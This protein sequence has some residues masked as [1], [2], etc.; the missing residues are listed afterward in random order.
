M[1]Y[2]LRRILNICNI[3]KITRITRCM[4]HTH[5]PTNI[6]DTTYNVLSFR[7]KLKKIL[8]DIDTMDITKF[9]HYNYITNGNI[10]TAYIFT[11][12]PNTQT[13]E[14]DIY[15]GYLVIS[16]LDNKDIKKEIIDGTENDYLTN[17]S[18]DFARK[19]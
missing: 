4:S 2:N 9:R 7:N 18:N 12:I 8:N 16:Q 15:E 19:N 14:S 6:S 11:I 5:S 10:E 13:K 1:A 3:H 17:K